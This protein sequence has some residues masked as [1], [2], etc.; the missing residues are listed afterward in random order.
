MRL[1]RGCQRRLD[2]LS[3]CLLTADLQRL[4]IARLELLVEKRVRNFGLVLG[5]PLGGNDHQ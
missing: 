4:D 5:I 3:E 1:D 2:E